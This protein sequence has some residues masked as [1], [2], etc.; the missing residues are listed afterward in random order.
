[1]G[2]LQRSLRGPNTGPNVTAW[3]HFGTTGGA[4]GNGGPLTNVVTGEMLP[5]GMVITNAGGPTGGGSS[6]GPNEGSPAAL[7][8]T[9]YIDWGSGGGL[10]HAFSCPARRSWRTFSRTSM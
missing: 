8:F 10:S 3:N 4:P 5:A 6:G 1:M 7:V 9:N 2:R